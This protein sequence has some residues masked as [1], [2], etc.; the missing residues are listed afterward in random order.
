MTTLMEKKIIMFGQGAACL[1]A[2]NKML[3]LRPAGLVERVY[4]SLLGGRGFEPRP[5]HTEDFKNGTYFLLVRRLA[6][7]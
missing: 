3:H 6:F 5:G 7:K 1:A 4:A 2:S